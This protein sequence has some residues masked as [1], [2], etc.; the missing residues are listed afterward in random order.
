MLLL[1]CMI[2]IRFLMEVLAPLQE[3]AFEKHKANSAS[4][5]V[6]FFL[7]IAK[8]AAAL[9]H[10]SLFNFLGTVNM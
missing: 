9:L 3:S 4:T 10:C 2:S 7:G 8:N 5:A 1:A 6:S